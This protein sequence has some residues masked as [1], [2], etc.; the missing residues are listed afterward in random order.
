MHE[1]KDQRRVSGVCS[2]YLIFLRQG[3]SQVFPTFLAIPVVFQTPRNS[4]VSHPWH[5]GSR[6]IWPYLVSKVGAEDLK[7]GSP[8]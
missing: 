8:A 5:W 2:H 3:L 7:S 1:C 6:H 4:P